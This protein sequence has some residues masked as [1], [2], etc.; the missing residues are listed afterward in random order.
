ML[1]DL[2]TSLGSSAR[3]GLAAGALLI[4]AGS[5][6]AATWLLRTDYQVLFTDLKPQDTAM[7]AAELDKLKVPHR[8]GP[9]GNTILV[10]GAIV[11][12]T[13]LKLM[14]KELPLH[15]ATGFE[16]FNNADF[17]MTEFAQKINYQRALQGEIT[18]TILSLAE[19]RDVRVHLALPE[20]GLF[21]RATSKAKAAITLSLKSGQS[22]RSE[23][24]IGIQ[25]LVAAAV[26]G[27][28]AQDVT[29]VDQQG[30]ALT[31]PAHQEGEVDGGSA[32]LDLKR[33]TE[34]QLVRKATEVLE[35]AFGAGQVLA[36]VDVTLN[37]DQV[38]VT[39]EEVL[40]AQGRT[41][42]SAAGVMVRERE[43]VRES[44]PPLAQPDSARGGNNQREV[45]YQVGRRV[46][47]VASQ[48]GAIR[49]LHVVAVIR[50]PVSPEQGER[51]RELVAAA[52]GAVPERGD[53]VVVQSIHS[54]APEPA[55]DSP[56][57]VSDVPQPRLKIATSLQEGEPQPD[58]LIALSVLL[59]AAVLGASAWMLWRRPATTEK[60]SPMTDAQR[61]AVLEQMQDWLD[62]SPSSTGARR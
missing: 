31:R 1:K 46:E 36:T 50:Q 55:P 22:L 38:R 62:V 32:R 30:V 48:P 39:T 41:G 33:D 10:D 43:S 20:E 9:D 12:A 58:A 51:M 40:G 53:V 29:I 37:M 42:S 17:G 24:V 35:G 54:F 60:A 6:A 25:R 59:L 18:R 49:R 61:Q 27:I 15:G 45:D 47:H 2:W 34:K 44:G 7:M 52:V 14:G 56:A 26:P 4:V 28:S 8:I 5:V 57:A 11:H 16:L 21:K 13:R 3:I 19:V 23:Q